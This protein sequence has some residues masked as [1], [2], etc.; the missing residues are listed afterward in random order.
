MSFFV[1]GDQDTILG[2]RFAGVPGAAADSAEDA[3]TALGEVTRLASCQILIV[4][5]KVA[6]M[7][8]AELTE[9]RLNCQPPFVVEVGD[10]WDTP[11]AR[12]GLEQMIHEAVGIRI[13]REVEEGG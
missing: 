9:H 6:Q 3:R 11:V 10:V 13:V 8:D 5:Q 2:F 12:K 1:I 4:T 7:L